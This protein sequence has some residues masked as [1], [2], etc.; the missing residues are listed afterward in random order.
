MSGVAFLRGVPLYI[1]TPP[2]KDIQNEGHLHRR[3]KQGG[4]HPPRFLV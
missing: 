1:H 3:R 4:S 2:I